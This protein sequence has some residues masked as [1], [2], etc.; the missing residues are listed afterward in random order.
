MDNMIFK[1]NET[2]SL[3]IE[4]EL[5]LIDLYTMD[6]AMEA[7]DFLQR[8]LPLPHF[9]EIKPEITQSMIEINSSIHQNYRSL[10]I[11]LQA[12]RDF[13]ANEALKTHIGICGGGTHPF[14]KWNQQR[15]FPSAHF[16]SRSEQYG[17]LAK[18]FSVFGQHIHI[19]CANGNDAL[20]LCHA[21]A[22]Y[23]PHF[24]A[25][26]ASSPFYEGMDTTF[27]CSRLNV[28][29]AFPLSGTPPWISEWDEFVAYF[30]KMSDLGVVKSTKDFYWDIRP[31]PEYGT[32]EI[33]IC[34]TPLTV[35]KS[36]ILA[37]YAQTLAA[38]LLHEKPIISKEVYLTYIINRFSAT[39][40][41]LDAEIVDP[42]QELRLPLADDIIDTCKKINEYAQNLNTVE[43][44]EQIKLEAS[45]K[46]NDATWLRNCF[47]QEKSLADMVRA[48][49]KLWLNQDLT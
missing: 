29:S 4:I 34:D 9:G 25:L 30:R 42:I 24:V 28:I 8:I 1:H 7:E 20:Y 47:A 10:I 43:A 46:I 19:G 31:K 44:L 22:R 33:R 36:A 35:E 18:K 32:V 45:A 48:Q 17:Y 37:A 41:G 39:R 27:D 13:L 12:T 15:I 5:Q 38:Y 11:E 23:M 26:S 16:K 2:I 6:L 14:Q 40:Y 21:L 3:G 49:S